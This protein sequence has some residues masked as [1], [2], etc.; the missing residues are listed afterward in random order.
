MHCRC[1]APRMGGA[2]LG[3]LG[4]AHLWAARAR[5]GAA[6]SASARSTAA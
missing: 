1:T 4:E 6:P 5:S 2:A 3:L